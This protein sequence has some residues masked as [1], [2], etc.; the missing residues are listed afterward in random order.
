MRRS[1]LLILLAI[2][3]IPAVHAADLS[4]P[5]GVWAPIENGRP[6]GLVRIFER[7]GVFF[8][9]IEPSSPSDDSSARCTRCTGDRRDQRLIGLVIM[10]NLKP[11]NGEYV[12]GDILDPRTG[13]VYDCKFRLMNGGDRLR[14]RGYLGV[15]LLGHSQIWI[16]VNEADIEAYWRAKEKRWEAHGSRR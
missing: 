1:I 11:R 3:L 7:D 14:M 10:R 8:G 2:P 6:L 12:G 5:Q 9:R 13:R 16:R 4:S 15:S